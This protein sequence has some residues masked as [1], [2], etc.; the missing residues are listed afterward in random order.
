MRVWFTHAEGLTARGQAVGGFEVAGDDHNFVPATAKIEKV[1]KN[2]TVLV[3]SP[4]LSFPRFV[5]YAWSGVV[6][7]F[8]YNDAGL[9]AGTFTSE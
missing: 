2:N 1:G 6:T 7:S 3:S 4:N 9:P 8:L 5:R